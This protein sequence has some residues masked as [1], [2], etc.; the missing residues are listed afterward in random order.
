MSPFSEFNPT[1]SKGFVLAGMMNMSVLVFS[2]FFTN[3]VLSETDP[4]V[5]SNFGL[6]MIILWGLAYISVAKCYQHVQWLVGIFA[7]EKLIYG[8]VWT[9]WVLN[10]DVSSIFSKDIFA[11]TFFSVYG[12]N[13][14]LFCIFF[15]WVFLKLFRNK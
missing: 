13:D 7:L 1:I 8:I 2:K 6:V 9:H 3:S 15:S 10:N 5:A 4:V 14:W 12:V 11:G